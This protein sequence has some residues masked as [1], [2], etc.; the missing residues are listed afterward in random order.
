MNGKLESRFLLSLLE[1]TYFLPG[2]GYYEVSEMRS[3]LL[4]FN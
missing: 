4:Q 2:R 3:Y 1:K